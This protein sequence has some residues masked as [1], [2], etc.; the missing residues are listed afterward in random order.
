[1]M[2]LPQ[3]LTIAK[4]AWFRTPE[5]RA[6]FHALNREGHEVRVVGG[7]VRNTLMGLPAGDVDFAT[8]ATPMQVKSLARK[9]G[10]K[11]I[12]T[13]LKHGTITILVNGHPFEVT[14]LRED[15]ETHGRHATVAFTRNWLSDAKRRD[16]TINALYADAEG[17]I[18]DPLGGLPDV[19]RRRVYF[20][21]LAHERIREDYL[22]ILRFF[23]FTAEYAE[24]GLDAAGFH[25]AIAERAGLAQLSAERVHAELWRILCSKTPMRALA[26]MSD[27]GLLT[28]ILGGVVHLTYFER[29][30]A[31]EAYLDLPCDP[32]RRIAALAIMIEEDAARLTTRLRLS[33]VES[34]RLDG[35][36]AYRPI[37]T[38]EM[39]EAS[40]REQLYRL[41]EGTY[42]D[43][44]L[45]A[46]ARAGNAVSDDKW[47]ELYTLPDRWQVPE[48]FLKG[49]DLLAAGVEKGPRVGETLRA[50]EAKWIASGFAMSRDELLG[51]I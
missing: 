39:S 22:R 44:V 18:Y 43:R 5:V 24:D 26:P 23:R 3:A 40:A 36:A 41:R 50:L 27:A 33:N 12:A 32:V 45:I 28:S 49:Q 19:Q 51:A 48:F 30:A 6:I 9:A 14:T 38:R 8:T 10:L 47:R 46:W 37:F 31:I 16:F 29:M 20:I 11:P 7:A 25:A 17:R 42:R 2:R 34:A 15:V 13:G 1:M 21:G 35:M 4:A